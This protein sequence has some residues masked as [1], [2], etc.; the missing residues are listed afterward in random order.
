MTAASLAKTL[1]A[2]RS[3][4]GQWMTRCPAHDDSS[5]SLSIREGR[6]GCVLVHCWAGCTLSAVLKALGLSMRDLFAG[7]PP[8]PEQVALLA[9][10]RQAKD[11]LCQR[12]RQSERQ[13][14][15]RIWKLE[16]IVNALG[17]KLA[18]SPENDQLSQFF[19]LACDRLHEAELTEQTT[20]RPVASGPHE[21]IA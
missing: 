3:G 5:P 20:K 7:P 6:D 8:A 9:R 15:T 1:R 17:C 16:R 4:A 19:H 12:E 18:R 14:R 21:R 13:P 11:A 2:R 10:E